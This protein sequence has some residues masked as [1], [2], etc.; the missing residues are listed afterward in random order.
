MDLAIPCL[1]ASGA[2]QAVNIQTAINADGLL[3][4]GELDALFGPVAL[5]PDPLLNQILLAVTVPL[6]VVKAG[7][8]LGQSDTM[9]DDERATAASQQD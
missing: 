9:T 2:L 5:F 4:V 6:D 7:R 8:F 1:D 3:T